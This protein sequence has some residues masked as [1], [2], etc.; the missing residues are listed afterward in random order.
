LAPSS[1][2]A[3]QA[4]AFVL[5]VT[6][7]SAEAIVHAR[8]AVDLNPSFSEAFV[9][10]ALALVFSGDIE[11]AIEAC[12]HAARS[13]PRDTRGTYLYDA[14]GHAHFMAGDYEQAIEVSKTGLSQDPSIYGTLVTL[15]AANAYLGRDDEAKRYLDELLLLIPRYSLSALRKNPMFVVPEHIDKLVEGMRLAGLPE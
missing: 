2:E 4:Q 1:P 12:H 6:G 3:N 15:A 8:R 14:L 9:V 13:S 11:G 5:V 7:R 10:L